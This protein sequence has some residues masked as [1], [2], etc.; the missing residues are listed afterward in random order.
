MHNKNNNYINTIT[1]IV[2]NKTSN[3]FVIQNKLKL[4][5]S[6]F[7]IFQKNSNKAVQVCTHLHK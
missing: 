5:L 7:Y 2:L 4:P 6:I 3:F 1:F